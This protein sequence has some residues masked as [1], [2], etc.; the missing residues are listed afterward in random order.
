VCAAV[1]VNAKKEAPMSDKH[2]AVVRRLFD[3]VWNKGNLT[4][5]DE[6]LTNDYVSHEPVNP[7]RGIPGF[8]DVVSKYRNAFPDC[9][10]DIDELLPA[11]GKVVARWR[12]SGTHQ[13]TFEGIPPTGRRVTGPGISIFR[14]QGD[15]IAEDYTN[16]DALGFMQ[17]LGVVTLPGKSQRVGM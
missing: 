6:L 11:G 7:A 15:R 17:Q 9:R 3:E 10:L 4:L 2:E 12:Y 8:R 5:L 1:L 13:N 14:F 16:W